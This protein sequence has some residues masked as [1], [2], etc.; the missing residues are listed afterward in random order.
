M[1]DS[2]PLL[3]GKSEPGERNWPVGDS[4]AT[5]D[6]IPRVF[7]DD[8]P[9]VPKICRLQ[10]LIHTLRTSSIDEH[11]TH[12]RRFYYQIRQTRVQGLALLPS[13]HRAS[14]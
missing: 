2:T 1:R 6:N 14:Q 11:L 10:L 3:Q 4:K 8:T 13:H 5:L 12:S 9:R 7:V